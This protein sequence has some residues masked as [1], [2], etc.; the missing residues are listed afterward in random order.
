MKPVAKYNTCKALSTVLTVGTP[1]ATMACCGDMFVHRS[2]TALSAAAVFAFLLSML[3]VKDKILNF[4][5]SPTALKVAV[6]GFVFCIVVGNLIETLRIVFG[7]TIAA[8]AVDEITFKRIYNNIVIGF[9]ENYKQ[10]EKFGFLITNSEKLVPEVITNDK[11][12]E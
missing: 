6:I 3:F 2:D 8:C 4:I 5:K 1:I 10:Y 7:M 11:P 9:P 12:N